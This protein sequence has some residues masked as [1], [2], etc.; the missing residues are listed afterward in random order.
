MET[1]PSRLVEEE[2]SV[3]LNCLEHGL[4]AVTHRHKIDSRRAI[5]SLCK[6]FMWK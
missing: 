3:G 4:N 1:K 2:A 5:R 6:V